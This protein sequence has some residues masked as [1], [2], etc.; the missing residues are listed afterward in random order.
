MA[1]AAT[2]ER[3]EVEST[4]VRRRHS[5]QSHTQ[6]QWYKFGA[7]VTAGYRPWVWTGLIFAL[8]G[9]A[10]EPAVSF[11]RTG[12]VM[13]TGPVSEKVFTDWKEI[14]THFGYGRTSPYQL[15]GLD[16]TGALNTAALEGIIKAEL[17]AVNTADAVAQYGLQS[18]PTPP[19]P[20]D[21]DE[22]EEEAACHFG[23]MWD[24]GLGIPKSTVHSNMTAVVE[25]GLDVDEW[26]AA[27]T[28]WLIAARTHF[29]D[30]GRQVPSH[31]V[32]HRNGGRH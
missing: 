10:V 1:S 5:K 20:T 21:G 24:R 19:C 13:C 22:G 4:S 17:I 32:L 14:S 7:C 30:L 11:A 12:G 6:S 15:V 23:R 29:K 18:I 9:L 16:G 26:G 27:G 28:A 3:F 31:A 25:F 8:C 2:T